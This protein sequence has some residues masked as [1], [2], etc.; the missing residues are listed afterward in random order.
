[1]LKK[2]SETTLPSLQPKD[3]L[4]DTL[5]HALRFNA[6]IVPESRPDWSDYMSMVSSGDNPGKSMVH[7]LPIIDLDPNDMCCIYS[8]LS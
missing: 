4:L 5:W 1:M 3:L 8:T 6:K 2:M 7:M